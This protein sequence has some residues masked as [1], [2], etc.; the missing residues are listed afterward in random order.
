MGIV[1]CDLASLDQKLSPRYFKT[2]VM[3]Q[4]GPGETR[5]AVPSDSLTD[6]QKEFQATK[7]SIHAAMVD[8]MD[9]EIGRV[10]TQLHAMD[11]FE[12]TVI[13]FLSDNGADATLLIRGDGHDPK[14]APGSAKSFLCIGPGWASASNTPF[15]RHKV[16]VSEGG[17]STPLI[18]HWPGRIQAHGA[19]RHDLGHVIDFVPTLLELAGGKFTNFWNGTTA[20]PLPGESLVPAFAR[21]GALKTHE[22]FFDHEGNRSLRVGDWKLVSARE[23]NDAWELFNLSKD[24][25]EKVNLAGREPARVEQMQARWTELEKTFRKQSGF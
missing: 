19:L 18:V 17:I 2:N 8:R 24:R 9:Q 12:N 7:M 11:A 23:D 21:D 6:E 20:P 10:V 5:Y 22:L 13:F 25:C 3:A 16:W 14:A 15:R 1:N 4:L